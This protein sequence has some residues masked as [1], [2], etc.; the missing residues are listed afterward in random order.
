MPDDANFMEK[1]QFPIKNKK[2]VS[3]I[4]N[5][6]ESQDNYKDEIKLN[7][8]KPLSYSDTESIYL[9]KETP[10]NIEIENNKN[11]TPFNINGQKR[12]FHSSNN[13]YSEDK[14]IMVN[15]DKKT[16]KKVV[17]ISDNISFY[18]DK[19]RDL[20]DNKELDK[21]EIQ[22]KIEKS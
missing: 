7:F 13:L 22:I 18:F 14:E 15:V 9:K 6:L 11:L 21:K 3:E 1:H 8:D 4:S 2:I 19:I 10:K 12:Y 16:N 20:I 5:I 17:K